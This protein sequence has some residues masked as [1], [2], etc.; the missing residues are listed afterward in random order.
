MDVLIQECFRLCVLANQAM[1][2]FNVVELDD[3]GIFLRVALDSILLDAV[4]LAAMDHFF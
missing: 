4:F 1:L 2:L 3:F